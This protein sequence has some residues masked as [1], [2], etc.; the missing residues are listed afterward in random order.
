MVF[1][2]AA[3]KNPVEISDDLMEHSSKQEPLIGPID[4]NR[5]KKYGQFSYKLGYDDIV[6]KLLSKSRTAKTKAHCCKAL[7]CSMPTLL[8][9]M[10]K[11]PS[12]NQAMI[13][14]LKIG[15]ANW[16]E[17]LSTNAFKPQQLVNNGLIKLLTSNV[18]GIKEDVSIKVESERSQEG[19]PEKLL[20]QRGIPLPGVDMEDF[21]D[22]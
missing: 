15:E 12:F 18:Y 11:Y 6:Y 13:S 5:K 16:R 3:R 19:N 17:R 8:R 21:E 1:G 14:G 10:K 20:R 2:M 9:W 7:L 4:R 22:D